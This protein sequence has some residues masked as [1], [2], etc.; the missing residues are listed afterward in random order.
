MIS[1][2]SSMSQHSTEGTLSTFYWKGYHNDGSR[3]SG[4]T[5]ALSEQEVF[6]QLAR[7]SISINRLKRRRVSLFDHYKHAIRRSDIILLT[8]QITTML[9]SGIPIIQS[10][11]LIQNNQYKA[12]LNTLL[13]QLITNLNAG[14]TL[15]ASLK[16]NHRHFDPFYINMVL[17]G[18]ETGNLSDAFERVVNYQ[19]KSRRLRAKT[20]KAMIYPI[21]VIL[22]AV[23][24][25]VLML[26]YVIPEFESIFHSFGAQLPWLTQQIVSSSKWLTQHGLKLLVTLL[27]ILVTF[28]HI[29]KRSLKCQRLISQYLLRLPLIG[30]IIAKTSIATFSATLAACYSAGVPILLGLSTASQS[31]RNHYYQQQFCAVQHSA[32][33]GVPIYLSMRQTNVFPEFVIQMVMIGEES[34]NL[35]KM[36]CRISDIY[37]D[38][39]SNTIDNLGKIL[40]PMI[41]VTLG[42]V[43]GAMVVAM[44]L[45]I[46]NLMN[47]IN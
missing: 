40:E 32:A 18:E 38:D 33:S 13:L 37:E 41:I 15:S 27:F 6:E 9:Q 17:V 42:I 7:E 5:V 35:E 46:F 31:C 12:E 36:L 26:I 14:L 22:A 10:L 4:K 29:R 1:Q 43:I 8:Q 19:Q 39:V 47:I 28:Q 25:T 34:G 20:I 3:V 45:P 2:R 21:T 16:A 23:T 44:Y 24:V 30:N 11:Q